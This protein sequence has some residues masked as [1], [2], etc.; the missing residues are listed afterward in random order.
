MSFFHYGGR[1]GDYSVKNLEHESENEM[2]SG[3]Y[4]ESSIYSYKSNYGICLNAIK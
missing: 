3:S 1:I 2:T 4:T